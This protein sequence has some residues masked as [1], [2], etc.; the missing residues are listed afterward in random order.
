MAI[1]EIL[2]QIASRFGE[3]LASPIRHPDMLWIIIP[4]YLN[5][6]VGDYF[7]ERKVTDFGNAMTNGVV[8]LW[9][10]IDWIRQTTKV[11]AFNV[12]FATKV[13]ICAVFIIYGIIVM[14]ETAKA[15]KI[16]HYIGRAREI[17]YFSVVAT[18]IFYGFISVDWINAAAI[19]MFFPIVYGL[20]SLW[21]KL[22]PAPPGEE[23][24]F[25]KMPDVGKDSMPDMGSSLPDMGMNMPQQSFGQ[26]NYQQYPSQQMPKF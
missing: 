13:A 15:K 20:N 2:I 23:D 17:G 16:A 26:Q 18:P 8:V 9:V 6:F 4:I 21:D 22:L 24:D 7:Q 10:G 1:A 11:V 25:G 3:I 19:L 12:E 5:W 14:I